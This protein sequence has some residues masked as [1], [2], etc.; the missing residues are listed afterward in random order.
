[1][2]DLD[3][4]FKPKSIAIVGAAHTETKLGGVVLRNLLGFR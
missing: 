4:F 2:T 3:L 1:M